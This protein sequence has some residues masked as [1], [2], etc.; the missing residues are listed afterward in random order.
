MRRHQWTPNGTSEL[1]LPVGSYIGDK[2]VARIKIIVAQEFPTR[3]VVLICPRLHNDI[4]N[5]TQGLAVRAVI[6]VGLDFEF[7]DRVQ[8]RLDAV[9]ADEGVVNEPIQ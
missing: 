1:V 9:V 3:A 5:S 7:L 8:D 2:R 6:I 4:H